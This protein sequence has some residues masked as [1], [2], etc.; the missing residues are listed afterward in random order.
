MGDRHSTAAYLYLHHPSA[1]VH[2]TDR[3]TKHRAALAEPPAQLPPWTPPYSPFLPSPAHSL[4][5]PPYLLLHPFLQLA[6]IP[7]LH[8]P[9]SHTPLPAVIVSPHSLSPPP[10]RAQPVSSPRSP[11][12]SRHRRREKTQMGRSSRSA[13]CSQAHP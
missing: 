5:A 13:A 11:P 8:T 7:E 12:R 9:A 2:P 1:A 10:Q 3:Q 6:R 4:H